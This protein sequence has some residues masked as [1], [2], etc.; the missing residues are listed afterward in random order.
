M[1][2]Y[3]SCTARKA[4]GSLVSGWLG[5]IDRSFMAMQYFIALTK[6]DYGI[7]SDGSIDM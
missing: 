7:F 3:A 1:A 5:M 6:S 2:E 4:R